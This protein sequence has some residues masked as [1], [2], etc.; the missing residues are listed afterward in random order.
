MGA[1]VAPFLRFDAR[2]VRVTLRRR[3]AA[4]GVEHFV[5]YGLHSFRRGHAMDLVDSGASLAT[6]LAA[7]GWKSCAFAAYLQMH[8]VEK[9]AARAAAVVDAFDDD[10]HSSDSEGEVEGVV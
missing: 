4:L 3:L 2:D 10:A 7:G 5:E 6:I 9:G 1:D 8:M